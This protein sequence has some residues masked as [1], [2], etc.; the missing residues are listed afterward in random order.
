MLCT[1]VVVL[2]LALLAVCFSVAVRQSELYA[3]Q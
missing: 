1:T 2:Q 3:L